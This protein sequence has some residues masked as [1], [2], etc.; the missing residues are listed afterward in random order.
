MRGTAKNTK[1]YDA[2][3]SFRDPFK[4]ILPVFAIFGILFAVL[5]VGVLGVT[6]SG[7]FHDASASNCVV[8]DKDR[9]KDEDG[10][11]DMR[12]YTDNCGVFTVN[13]SILKSQFNSADK[14]AKIQIGKTYDFKANGWRIPVMSVFPNITGATESN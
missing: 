13:D 7:N 12:I 2:S 10:G 3:S 6:I 5:F 1:N 8:N 14:Y 9:T 4:N 11:S